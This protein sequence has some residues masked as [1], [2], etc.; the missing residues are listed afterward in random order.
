MRR[1]R[2]DTLPQLT[3]FPDRGCSLGGPSCLRCRLKICRHDTPE[4]N[5]SERTNKRHALIAQLVRQGWPWA[6]IMAHMHVSKRTVARAVWRDRAGQLD[7]PDPPIL[8]RLRDLRQASALFRPYRPP[9][10]AVPGR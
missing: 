5:W 4:R 1:V 2:K 9:T 10:F 7:I 3:N 6:T 8:N